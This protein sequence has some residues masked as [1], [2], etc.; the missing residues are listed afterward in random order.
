MS[1]NDAPGQCSFG[2]LL[3][4]FVPCSFNIYLGVSKIVWNSCIHLSWAFC[5]CLEV[6]S[7]WWRC[8]GATSSFL[9]TT[10]PAYSRSS[11][12]AARTNHLTLIRRELA[13][14]HRQNPKQTDAT[15]AIYKPIQ[16]LLAGQEG[17][18][19]S[20]YPLDF[21]ASTCNC[22]SM[23]LCLLGGSSHWFVNSVRL[24]PW[25]VWDNPK[26]AGQNLEAG[27]ALRLA[28]GFFLGRKVSGCFAGC[29]SRNCGRSCSLVRL[30]VSFSLVALGVLQ[31]V[32]RVSVC[33]PLISLTVYTRV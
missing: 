17:G 6:Q 16:Q 9:C 11:L 5:H 1:R 14:V 31:G 29:G 12:S 27:S 22:V 32:L 4:H 7:C 8:L 18:A 26:I 23:Q 10:F 13:D 20:S 21:V 30:C 19:P 28:V 3:L 2:M 33:C 25:G 24:C 15:K